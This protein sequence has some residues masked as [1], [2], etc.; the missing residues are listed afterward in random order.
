MCALSLANSKH[1]SQIQHIL[2]QLHQFKIDSTMSLN[3]SS[4]SKA[5]VNSNTNSNQIINA[6]QSRAKTANDQNSKNWNSTS[7]ISKISRQYKDH[8]TAKNTS[9]S[10]L[11]TQVVSRKTIK[12]VKCMKRKTLQKVQNRTHDWVDVWLQ[13]DCSKKREISSGNWKRTGN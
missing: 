6:I 8:N 9:S 4:N 13:A 12:S 5:N 1:K 11:W 3:S 10:N 2:N 7:V